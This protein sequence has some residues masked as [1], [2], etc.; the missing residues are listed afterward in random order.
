MLLMKQIS[1]T[2][3]NCD[4]V[5]ICNNHGCTYQTRFRLQK[6]K[7]AKFGQVQH[8]NLRFFEY[9][10]ILTNLIAWVR[11]KYSAEE[12]GTES[13][14]LFPLY[15]LSQLSFTY[16]LKLF[17]HPHL[18]SSPYAQ[19]FLLSPPTFPPIFYI[20]YFFGEPFLPPPYLFLSPL[21]SFSEF[22]ARLLALPLA[23]ILR[24]DEKYCGRIGTRTTKYSTVHWTHACPEAVSELYLSEVALWLER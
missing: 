6:P 11:N 24:A 18:S 10:S 19:R 4:W 13:K 12:G 20:S 17:L 1:L 7:I 9:V 16:S 21:C 8:G 5:R 15:L 14:S 3:E 22:T 2:W 23:A